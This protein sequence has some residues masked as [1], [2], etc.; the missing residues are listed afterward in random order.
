MEVL[1]RVTVPHAIYQWKQD[2]QQR[3][4]AEALQRNNR[5]ALLS[6]FDRGLAI[7][8]YERDAS[9][10]GSFLLGHWNKSS[11]KG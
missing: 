4:L 5:T 8:G 2:P 6:A 10:D 7:T 3:S 9:G 11:G 1:E